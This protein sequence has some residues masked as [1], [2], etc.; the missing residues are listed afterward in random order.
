VTRADWFVL[1]TVVLMRTFAGGVAGGGGTGLAV[2]VV[3]APLVP[4]ALVAV[5]K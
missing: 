2:T 5:T 1:V 3:E 4:P